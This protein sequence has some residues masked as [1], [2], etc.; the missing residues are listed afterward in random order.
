MPDAAPATLE[1]ILRVSRARLR[2]AGLDDPA[3]EARILVEHF[4]ETTRAHAITAPRRPVEPDVAGRILAA[5]ERRRK[6]EPVFRIIGTREFCGLDFALSPSTLEPRQDTEVLVEEMAVTAAE[7]VARKG[8]CWILDLGTG[9]G[10]I[11]LSLLAQVAGTRA[12]GV[13]VSQEALETSVLNADALGVGERF[14]ALRS[15]WFGAVSG[16]YDVIVSNPPYIPTGIIANLE[17][18]VRDFDPPAALDGGEDGLDAY[19]RIADKA[20]D[21]LEE[22][23]RLGVEIGHDQ[24]LDVAVIFAR[25]GFRLVAERRDL[26]GSD[27]VLVFAVQA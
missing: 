7:V 13:D 2:G 4:T 23:G 1:E 10:A 22:G 12:V 25:A 8:Q 14:T 19:R 20:Q 24:R 5:V 18:E 15:D 17:P 26:T 16:R 11:A 27:R 3:L 21:H 9:T 6:G